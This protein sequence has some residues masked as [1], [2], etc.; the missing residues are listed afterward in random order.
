M[1]LTYRKDD[2]HTRRDR[3]LPEIEVTPE[4]IEAGASSIIRAIAP[5][6]LYAPM[7]EEKLARLVFEAM[8]AVASRRETNTSP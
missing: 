6:R 7:D 3:P 2:E 4:M 8:M 1:H 5:S